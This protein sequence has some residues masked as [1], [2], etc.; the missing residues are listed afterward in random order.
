MGKVSMRR[1]NVFEVLFSGRCVYD[2]L[3]LSEEDLREHIINKC[4]RC[5][6]LCNL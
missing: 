1:E 5:D 4:F 6:G 2:V 3:R